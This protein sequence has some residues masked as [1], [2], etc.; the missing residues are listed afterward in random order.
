MHIFWQVIYLLLWIFWA[1][2]I[3]RLV[4][5]LVQM[6]ARSWA[7]RGVLLVL[8][9]GVYTA[10]DPPIKALRRIV[11][12]IRLGGAAIDLSFLI[13]FIVTWVVRD[14]IVLPLAQ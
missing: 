13:L 6:F 8:L 3:V 5:D 11:P 1:L 14:W 9:E 10:T 2:L 4:A 12:P 7:P